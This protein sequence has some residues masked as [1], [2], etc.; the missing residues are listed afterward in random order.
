M[1]AFLSHNKTVSYKFRWSPS[2]ALISY[3]RRIARRVRKKGRS[4]LRPYTDFF[5][6]LGAPLELSAS[7]ELGEV[8]GTKPLQ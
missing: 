3:L 5:N 1:D 6:I 7:T 4:A 8:F 2:F